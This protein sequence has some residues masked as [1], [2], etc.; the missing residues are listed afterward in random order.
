[1][2]D[3]TSCFS[4]TQLERALNSEFE[5]R[6]DGSDRTLLALRLL[7]IKT[8]PAPPGYE[9]FSALFIGPTAP[10]MPQGNYRFTHAKLGETALFMVPVGRASQGMQYE[11]CI[12][13]SIG[14]G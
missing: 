5:I 12:S 3:A 7:E 6:P 1:M 8:R 14:E 13:H 4:Q 11:V 2:K 10:I 9:Q